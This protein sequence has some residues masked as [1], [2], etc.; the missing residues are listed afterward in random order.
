MPVYDRRYRGY[1]GPRTAERFRFLV[2]TRHALATLFD[3]RFNTLLFAAACLP[4]LGFMVAIYLSHNLEALTLVG[5]REL[6]DFVAIDA[7]FF[8]YFLVTQV[9]LGFLVTALFGP[10]LV[11]P[12][13][14]HDAL[15]LMLSRPLARRE[16]VLGKFVVLAG[17]FSAITWIP[18]LLLYLIQAILA[19]GGWGWKNLGVAWAVFAGSWLWIGVAALLALAV[20]AWVRIRPL[21]TAAI[22]GVF[23][24]GAG[25]GAA[26]NELLDT[27]WGT[28]LIVDDLVE[29]LWAHLFGRTPA[30]HALGVPATL[31]GL[32]G[33]YAFALY[34]LHR[35]VR[36]REVAR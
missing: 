15:P 2:L 13:L 18:G 34:L 28:L 19:G 25:F 5:V 17:L 9:G 14:A 35:K 23:L 31:A 21:A 24:V 3:S 26:I 36:A 10:A 20:S 1:D 29:T 16:Y 22:L 32:A 27:R 7:D 30:E 6:A 12:D 33:F 8:F 11:A 4:P